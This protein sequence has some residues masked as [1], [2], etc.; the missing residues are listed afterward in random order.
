M[1]LGVALATA[2]V[3]LMMAAPSGFGAGE[4]LGLACALTFGLYILAVNALAR[5]EDPWRMTAGQFLVVGLACFITCAALEGPRSVSP[6]AATNVLLSGRD[7]WLNV[8]LLTLFPTVGAFTLL[9]LYQPRLDPTRAALIYLVEPIIATGYAWVMVDRTLDA[10]TVVGAG[11]ILAANVV[12]EVLAA[13]RGD[14]P[15]DPPK[16]PIDPSGPSGSRAAARVEAQPA[17]SAPR[18]AASSP[19]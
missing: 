17:A 11:L 19:R 2:G 6:A 8:A 4:A 14:D 5:T 15:G 9:N 13:R 1:W 10:Y 16:S 12:V 7:V 3:W 18:P